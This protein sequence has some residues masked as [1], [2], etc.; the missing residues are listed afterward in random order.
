VVVALHP[1]IWGWDIK[2][3]N[4]TSQ[5]FQETPVINFGQVAKQRLLEGLHNDPQRST[6][7]SASTLPSYRKTSR[8]SLSFKS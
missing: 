5:K 2:S 6:G 1:V 7:S 3:A 8:V 4:G